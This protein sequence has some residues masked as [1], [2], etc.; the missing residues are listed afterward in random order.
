MNLTETQCP[1]V[2]ILC[3]IGIIAVLGPLLISQSGS[4]LLCHLRF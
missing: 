4:S 1:S 3:I 2:F